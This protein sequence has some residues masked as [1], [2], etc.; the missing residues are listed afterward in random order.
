MLV[1]INMINF[2][3]SIIFLM[4]VGLVTSVHS[5]N[6][7]LT[8][9]KAFNK[10]FI[11]PWDCRVIVRPSLIENDIRIFCDE[12]KN[13]KANVIHIYFREPEKC[14]PYDYSKHG[15]EL[16]DNF[17]VL[18]NH[19]TSGVWFYEDVKTI[20]MG[21]ENS[22]KELL[23]YQRMIKDDDICMDLISQTREMLIEATSVIWQE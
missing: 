19:E 6:S 9:F 5:D 12:Y 20:D 16:L 23:Q 13:N 3:K 14:K 22:S 11:F 8:A 10:E 7:A 4:L 15:N 1:A 2:I 18:Q 17:S 21:S